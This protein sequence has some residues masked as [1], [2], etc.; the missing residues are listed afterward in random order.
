VSELEHKFKWP[1]LL[2]LGALL[3]LL[4]LLYSA[5]K[6]NYLAFIGVGILLVIWAFAKGVASG[7]IR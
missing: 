1:N 7:K 6:I 2:E 3:T 5:V 4:A